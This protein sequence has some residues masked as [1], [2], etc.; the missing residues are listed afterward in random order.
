[1]GMKIEILGPACN[2]CEYLYRY[3]QK[4]I[5]ENDLDAEVRFVDRMEE[6]L[7]LGVMMTPAVIIDGETMSVGRV[8]SKSEIR[9]WLDY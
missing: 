5:V 8:P 4:V 2:K 6:I 7:K 3:I 1:M 9:Q